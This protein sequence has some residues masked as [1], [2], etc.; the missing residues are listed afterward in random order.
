MKPTF[1]VISVIRGVALYKIIFV[2][3]ISDFRNGYFIKQ[4]LQNMQFYFIV[5]CLTSINVYIQ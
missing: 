3:W 5:M 1:I 2:L 4:K